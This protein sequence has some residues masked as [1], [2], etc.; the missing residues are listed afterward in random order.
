MI[1]KNAKEFYLFK[2][3]FFCLSWFPDSGSQQA[4]NLINIY[5]YIEYIEPDQS[6]T[7]L[8]RID[9]TWSHFSFVTPRVSYNDHIF[10]FILSLPEWVVT[11]RWHGRLNI[12]VDILLFELTNTLPEVKIQKTLLIVRRGALSNY[13]KTMFIFF[14]SFSS[15]LLWLGNAHATCK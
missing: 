5:E 6:K 3:W 9:W 11:T 14:F 8:T 2:V 1:R 15:S 4:M 12:F 7:M 13:N 10:L